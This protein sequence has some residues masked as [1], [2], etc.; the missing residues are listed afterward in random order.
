[1]LVLGGVMALSAL[2]LAG[3]SVL[4]SRIICSVA[5]VSDRVFGSRFIV[6]PG[7]WGSCIGIAGAASC[8]YKVGVV[9]GAVDGWGEGAVGAY[10]A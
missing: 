6:A 3:A 4:N 8:G 1:V 5:M 10:G 9:A 2:M 7:L